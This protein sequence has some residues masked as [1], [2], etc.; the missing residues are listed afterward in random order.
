MKGKKEEGN[1][2]KVTNHLR[3]KFGCCLVTVGP[4]S[5][6]GNPGTVPM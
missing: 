2:E 3:P 6:L 1:W 4:I 5:N